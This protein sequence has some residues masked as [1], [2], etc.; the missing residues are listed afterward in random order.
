MVKVPF[1]VPTMIH[2]LRECTLA[3]GTLSPYRNITCGVPQGSILGPSLFLLFVNDMPKVVK[4][5]KISQYADDTVLYA[6]GPDSASVEARLNSDLTALN[7]WCREN[8]LM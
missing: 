1:P 3:N 2:L 5:S 4:D 7:N 8:K 6:S